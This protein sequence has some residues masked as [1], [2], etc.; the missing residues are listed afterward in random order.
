MAENI[1]VNSCAS[2][3]NSRHLSDIY[4]SAIANMWSQWVVSLDS[5][6]QIPI[7]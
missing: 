5:F 6:L 7:L 3:H 2:F 1:S 4:G